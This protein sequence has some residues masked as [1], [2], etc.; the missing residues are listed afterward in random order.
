MLC[1]ELTNNKWCGTFKMGT[2]QKL[3]KTKQIS[4]KNIF[5]QTGNKQVIGNFKKIIAIITLSQFIEE[6]GNDDFSI[7]LQIIG[8]QLIYTW[9]FSLGFQLKT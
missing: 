6:K 1:P 7:E 4:L 5:C 3:R 8:T 2:I 9:D